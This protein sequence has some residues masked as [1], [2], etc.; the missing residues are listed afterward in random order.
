M[1]QIKSLGFQDGELSLVRELAL[2]LGL[3][4]A[5]TCRADGSGSK[6]KEAKEEEVA[7][8]EISKGL[9]LVEQWRGVE[10]PLS[11][12][13][14]VVKLWQAWGEE[15]SQVRF[16]V[17]RISQTNPNTTGQGS[18]LAIVFLLF[19]WLSSLSLALYK[20]IFY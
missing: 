8:R 12:S 10:R 7:S 6:K 18:S 9:V 16:V 3:H 2:C 17:K 13:S 11:N 19:S 5:I 1:I 20:I 14:R 15:R 4:D